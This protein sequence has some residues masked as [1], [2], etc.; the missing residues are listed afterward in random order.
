MPFTA[1]KALVKYIYGAKISCDD[2]EDYF[3]LLQ[4]ASYYMIDDK[5]FYQ[6]ISKKI[7]KS[8][9][10]K[11]AKKLLNVANKFNFNGIEEIMQA[12]HGV[13]SYE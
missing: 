4:E 8:I 12:I 3:W 1:F 10:G 7:L 9:E 11:N 2:I 5:F 13:T 6:K